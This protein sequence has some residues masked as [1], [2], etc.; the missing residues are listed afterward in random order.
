MLST[1]HRVRSAQDG[2]HH[3]PSTGIPVARAVKKTAIKGDKSTWST[4]DS[5]CIFSENP[6]RP[7]LH[8]A[9]VEDST[10]PGCSQGTQGT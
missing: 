3:H 8:E 7:G 1:G 10:A 5:Q 4:L 2:G 6:E 9:S